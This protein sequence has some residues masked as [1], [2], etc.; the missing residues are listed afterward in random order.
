MQSVLTPPTR[1]M[2]TKAQLAEKLGRLQNPAFLGKCLCESNVRIVGVHILFP[3]TSNQSNLKP[4]SLSYR[5][6]LGN[7]FSVFESL[8]PASWDK[9][10][11][12][13]E[14]ERAYSYTNDLILK[15]GGS[16][17]TY[18]TTNDG[19]ISNPYEYLDSCI[20]DLRF[21]AQK[22]L[23]AYEKLIELTKNGLV[24]IF[25]MF[26]ESCLARAKFSLER[27]AR[28]EHHFELKVAQNSLV[29]LK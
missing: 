26:L 18:I 20:S 3:N 9:M 8:N 12:L 24:F 15:M 13:V 11:L 23:P 5:R 7:L 2:L 27:I 6:Y 29:Y 25:G 28:D 14:D 1:P 19:I 16:K 10:V 4:S 22:N 17:P 21:R